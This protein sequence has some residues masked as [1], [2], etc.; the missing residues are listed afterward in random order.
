MLHRVEIPESFLSRTNA[1]IARYSKQ[2]E[3]FPE[4]HAARRYFS[5]HIMIE[6]SELPVERNRN[7]GF[8]V[9]NREEPQS[10]QIRIWGK[11]KTLGVSRCSKPR[12][13]MLSSPENSAT[14]LD[15]HDKQDI[16]HR[17]VDEHYLWKIRF[18]IRHRPHLQIATNW[19]GGVGLGGH[20]RWRR[21][22][23]GTV[24]SLP[25]S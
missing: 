12:K 4:R 15:P 3:G 20:C 23:L 13:R 19:V 21:A 16:T 9:V 7:S 8:G 22:A 25:A 1:D 18:V 17:S 14:L 2:L 6:S 5:P 10:R 11:T 24:R